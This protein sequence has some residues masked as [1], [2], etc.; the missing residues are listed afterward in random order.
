MR[1]SSG[2]FLLAFA[3]AGCYRTTSLDLR[4]VDLVEPTPEKKLAVRSTDGTTKIYAADR[5]RVE[6]R[7]GDESQF[8]APLSARVGK[9][10]LG[11]A[12]ANREQSYS[13]REVDELE[14]EADA[15]G[16]PWV[17]AA[18]TL[19]TAVFGAALGAGTQ[20]CNDEWGCLGPTMAGLGGFL[21]G[22]PVGLALSIP[23]SATLNPER[24]PRPRWGDE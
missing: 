24:K 14:L 20:S 23:L 4:E 11:V 12:D 19:G 13:L 7:T 22:F 6:L 16:R 18:A 21:I 3:H 10:Q 15:P 1:W 9:D 17:I 2:L 8:E 5:V